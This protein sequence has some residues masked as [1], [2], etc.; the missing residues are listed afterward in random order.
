LVD[1]YLK[2]TI[3]RRWSFLL[4][5]LLSSG[6]QPASVSPKP[7]IFCAASL[8]HVLRECL[9]QT[10]LEAS[11]QSGGSTVLVTQV[12]AGAK[13]DILLLADV[14]LLAQIPEHTIL[15]SETLAS[16]E[17]VVIR[18]KSATEGSPSDWREPQTRLALANPKTAPLGRYTEQALAHSASESQRVFAK[19]AVAVV[20][21][22]AL[23]HADFGIVYKTDAIKSS[24]VEIVST[25]TPES[26]DTIE[27]Q[28]VLLQPGKAAAE[29]IYNSMTSQTG[30]SILKDN[31]F[32]LLQ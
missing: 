32:A 9:Q 17:L 22:V 14:R 2:K 7:T 19:D 28:I 21:A 31:G 1:F 30:R 4:C 25:F 23:G 15:R 29:E 5:L 18:P 24:A 6:C 10:K 8:S 3:I 11:V 12:K 20:T 27:Y 13:A 26:Y 16:N